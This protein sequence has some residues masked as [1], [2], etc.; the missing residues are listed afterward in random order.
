MVVQPSLLGD[1]PGDEDHGTTAGGL[2]VRGGVA[3]AAEDPVA[4]VLVETQLPHLARPFDYAVPATMDADARPGVR[5]RVRFAGRL[6]SGFILERRSDTEHVGEL[7]TLSRVVSPLPVLTPQL[8]RLCRSVADRYA[9]TLPDVLRLA[10]PPRHARA[11]KA[12]LASPSA[13]MSEVALQ[14]AAAELDPAP[15]EPADFTSFLTA[16]RSWADNVGEAHPATG[17]APPAEEAALPE[18][19]PAPGPAPVPRGPRAALGVLPGQDPGTGWIHLGMR[20]A[21]QALEAGRSVLWLV[22]DYREIAAVEARLGDLE[23]ASARLSADQGQEERWAAWVSVLTGRARLV[24]GTRAAAFAPLSEP[25]LVICFD[26]DNDSYLEQR[27]PYPHARQVLL[28]RVQ[29][30][31]SALLLLGY[32][33]SVEVQHLVATGWVGEITIPRESRRAASP[34]VFVPDPDGDPAQAGR[35]PPRAFELVR[36]A[37]GRTRK[38]TATGPVLV[39]VPRSGYLP[40]IACA[41]CRTVVRCPQCESKVSAA[42]I[43]GPFACRTCG[44]R[45]DSMSCRECGATSVRSV[46]SG[47]DKVYEELGRAFPG[48]RVIRSGGDRVLLD[49]DSEPSIVVATTGAEPYTQGGYAVALLLDTL[50]PGPGMRGTDHAISRR[51]RA[52]SL[53]RSREHGGRILLLDEDESVRR[54]LTRFEPVPWAAEQWADRVGLGLPPGARTITL[55]GPRS[56]VDEVLQVLREVAEVRVLLEEDDP[57][58]VVAACDIP[59]GRAVTTRLA[60]EIASRSMRGAEQVS[61]RVDDPAAL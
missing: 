40:V 2:R 11:E 33:R 50:W 18:Q 15:D 38:P 22:P 24:I 54:V 48:T 49:V 30:S 44:Y 17:T 34:L 14:Q 39:Q 21:A 6:T 20:A 8:L 10:I 28:N 36:E 55:D 3:P 37:L 47:V 35:L 61:A 58:R 13:R 5:V 29:Q 27:A 46:V 16:L 12:V 45:A 60:A 7:S 59:A 26:D 31:G 42:S 25:A 57:H 56:A 43:L 4:V 19:L 9:G 23:P 41:R 51:L 1:E 32:D 53:V 52:A